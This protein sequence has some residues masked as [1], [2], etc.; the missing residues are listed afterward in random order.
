MT[1]HGTVTTS[2]D[3][4]DIVSSFVESLLVKLLAICTMYLRSTFR[5]VQ[6]RD[7]E[8]ASKTASL[9]NDGGVSHYI[10][11]SEEEEEEGRGNE[12][13]GGKKNL[14]KEEATQSINQYSSSS[15][16]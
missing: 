9:E 5:E 11:V 3:S 7:D 10:I 1:F 13:L 16:G 14:G 4:K 8:D 12:E 2:K 6:W 15:T